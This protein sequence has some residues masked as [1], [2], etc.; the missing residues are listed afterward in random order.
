LGIYNFL[1]P[2]CIKYVQEV[3]KYIG[4][5]EIRG[6]GIMEI[7]GEFSLLGF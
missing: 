3:F 6:E 2:I 4:G 5:Y 1:G 7:Q